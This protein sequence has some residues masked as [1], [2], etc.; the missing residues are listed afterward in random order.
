M[1][2]VFCG[3]SEADALL[4]TSPAS[5]GAIVSLAP[6]TA[7][8]KDFWGPKLF[9]HEPPTAGDMTSFLDF[10]DGLPKCSEACLLLQCC[11]GN[12]AAPAFAYALLCKLWGRGTEMAALMTT[13]KA[14]RT[15]NPSQ[16]IVEVAD[17][18]LC[19]RGAMVAALAAWQQRCSAS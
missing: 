15:A 5:V 6:P 14:R 12:E 18:A 4:A 8:V 17:R 2:L 13:L 9:L 1:H 11:C 16:P 19:R 10:V 3:R 7:F